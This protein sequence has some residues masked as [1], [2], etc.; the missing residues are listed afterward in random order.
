MK[1]QA[2]LASSMSRPLPSVSPLERGVGETLSDGELIDSVRAGK[3]ESASELYERL[4][5]V[6]DRTLRRVL[7]RREADHD[8]L[9]QQSFEQIVKTLLQHRFAGECNLKTWAS[10]LTARTAFSELRR[11]CRQRR[12]LVDETVDL[13][14]VAAADW[15]DQIAVQAELDQV[16][17]ALSSLRPERAL[18]V[19]LHDVEG[20][21]LAEISRMLGSSISAVQSRL[22]RGRAQFL[23]RHRQLETT[24]GEHCDN[25][26]EEA[27]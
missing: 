6:V 11:R 26:S 4:L 25:E 13:E 15:R 9:I 12:M 16:R 1:F 19:Y 24:L 22:V 23:E 8:D 20:H 7:G 2:N 14:R 17:R 10:A 21:G 18:I 27:P 3:R 5:P